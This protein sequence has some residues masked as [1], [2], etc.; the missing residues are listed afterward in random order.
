MSRAAPS[1]AGTLILLALSSAAFAASWTP[2]GPYG[3]NVLEFGVDPA[4]ALRITAV[5]ETGRCA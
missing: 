5:T 3:G 2:V 4:N 1:L